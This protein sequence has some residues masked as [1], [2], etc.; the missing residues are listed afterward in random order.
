MQS[1]FLLSFLS[2]IPPIRFKL[3]EGRDA[4]AFLS[5]KYTESDT[6]LVLNKCPLDPKVNDTP[7][8]GAGHGNTQTSK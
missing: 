6:E 5:V 3:L 7:G 2:N 4:V 8:T 1:S